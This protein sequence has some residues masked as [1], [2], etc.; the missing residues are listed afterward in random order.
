VTWAGP[1][2]A[3]AP[4]LGWVD[5][6]PDG[7]GAR[8]LVRDNPNAPA[9]GAGGG[10]GRA[11]VYL[12]GVDVPRARPWDHPPVRVVQR[13]YTFRVLQGDGDGRDGFVRRGDAVEMVSADP[14]FYALHAGGAAFFSLAFPDPDVP[15]RRTLDCSGLVDLTSATGHYWMRAYLFV[16]DQP[17]YA[18]TDAEGQFVLRGVPPGEYEV[19]CWLPSWREAAHERDPETSLVTR[20]QFRPPVERTQKVRL[21]P[22]ETRQVTFALSAEDF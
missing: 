12:R 8:R 16:D 11:V 6:A 15:R 7:S 3:V 20:V 14:A 18:H 9:V 2:P 4:L 5:V 17:Y 19:V 13:D 10:V 21:G 1:V 22:R